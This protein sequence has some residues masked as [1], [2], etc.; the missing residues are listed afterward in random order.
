MEDLVHDGPKSWIDNWDEFNPHDPFGTGFFPVDDPSLQPT[1]IHR[2][3]TQLGSSLD[4][5][6]DFFVNGTQSD[7]EVENSAFVDGHLG[8]PKDATSNA[9]PNHLGDTVSPASIEC[10]LRNLQP[11]GH[12]ID[13]A[14]VC[15]PTEAKVRRTEKSTRRFTKAQ[16][17][18]LQNW[19]ST[20]ISYPYPTDTDKMELSVATGLSNKQ[21][22]DWFS[23]TR[24]RKLSP[25][26]KSPSVGQTTSDSPSA[27]QLSLEVLPASPAGSASGEGLYISD[28]D[29]LD[30]CSEYMTHKHRALK[31]H[32]GSMLQW[33]QDTLAERRDMYHLRL[34]H[35][36]IDCRPCLLMDR[37][38]ERLARSL[39]DQ[40]CRPLDVRALFDRAFLRLVALLDLQLMNI[41]VDVTMSAL[42]RAIGIQ[43]HGLIVLSLNN[44]DCAPTK[45]PAVDELISDIRGCLERSDM[46][47]FD[48]LIGLV[49]QL[50]CILQDSIEVLSP[51][52][53]R[54]S[55]GIAAMVQ[56]EAMEEADVASPATME[57]PPRQ[58]HL[59]SS[60]VASSSTACSSVSACSYTS[61]GRRKGRRR[62][63][64]QS[65]PSHGSPGRA[66]SAASL[67]GFEEGDAIYQCTFCS[68][69][70][71]R[72]FTWQRHEK[73]IHLPS[74]S[75]I[76]SHDNLPLRVRDGQEACWF[77][78][79]SGSVGFFEPHHRHRDLAHQCSAKPLSERTFYRR[80]H[81]VQ[82][83]RGVH[84]AADDSNAILNVQFFEQTTPLTPSQL[85]CPLC[86]ELMPSWKAR[87]AHVSRHFEENAEEHRKS[88][89]EED[90]EVM[91]WDSHVAGAVDTAMQGQET[92][93][94]TELNGDWPGNEP[95]ESMEMN[96]EP[97]TSF[98]QAKDVMESDSRESAEIDEMPKP[99]R[100]ERWK[101]RPQ[102]IRA[103]HQVRQMERSHSNSMHWR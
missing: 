44:I 93:K 9:Y 46:P 19:I 49:S 23:R 51:E 70:F 103:W 31:N 101:W 98:V 47:I 15:L 87:V 6:L 102:E 69:R 41:N 100:E 62:P 57:Q 17:A 64:L 8:F 89:A 66:S 59:D 42:Y 2:S 74:K 63:A 92:D 16:T 95:D 33:W 5:D 13:Q 36:R 84:A 39:H 43:D 61:F 94:V 25:I 22:G 29:L 30:S 38:L 86:G 72:K 12:R 75:W 83:L 91:D 60:S 90:M 26:A 4:V 10:N 97:A 7:V 67:I 65:S 20:N 79:S 45:P 73:S 48:K 76:C 37:K 88:I 34:P 40:G 11:P 14:A 56:C 35:H 58:R 55:S 78:P 77:C 1:A 52:L 80:D 24:L 96:G 3:T 82:H 18:I 21:I 81:L 71:N 50:R 28:D 27:I 54:P 68:K 53:F 99:A 32:Q 85:T